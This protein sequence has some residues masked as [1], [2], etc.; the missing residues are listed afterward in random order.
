MILGRSPNL[1]L[2]FLTALFNLAVV[3][4]P[5][6]FVPTMEQI[7]AVNVALGAAVAVIANSATISI[8]AG[9]AA[10]ARRNKIK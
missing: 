3:F 8:A 7:A 2:G 6:G 5:F 4:Q 1:I 9:N 10:A